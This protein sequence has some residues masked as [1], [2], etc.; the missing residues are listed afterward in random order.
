[1]VDMSIIQ[2]AGLTEGEAKVYLATLKLGT[3]T[4]GPIIEK[5]G[6]ANSIIYRILNGLIK[7]GLVSYVV[8]NK[9]KY[10]QAAKPEKIIEY[11]EER[12]EK[13][14]ESRE[15]VEKLIPQLIS[16]ANPTGETS[17]QVFE[18]FKGFLTAWE[19]G[20]KKLKK[21][22]EYHCW[23]VYP[24]QEERFHMYWQRDHLRRAKAGFKGKILFNRG[25]DPKILKNRNSYWG[26]EARYM[27]SDLKTPAWFVVYKNVT[28]I[29]LQTR[30]FGI[31]ENERSP[32]TTKPISVVII[33]QE[34]AETFEAHFQEFWKKSKKFS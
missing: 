16:L 34:I 3:S 9:T 26:C 27:S 14:N 23:G 25:T 7:K 2:D 8:K 28:I 31:N 18:G 30:K 6:V 17:V 20:Y 10:F 29:F 13:L 24:V 22:E 21:G 32:K 33:N 11:I 1:M 19:M 15:K 5:S 12:K 4:T